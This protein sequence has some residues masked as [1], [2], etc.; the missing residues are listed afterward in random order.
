[1]GRYV[2][3]DNKGFAD[4]LRGEYVDKTGLV[5]L[6]D[7]TLETPRK[8]V[9]VSCPRRF[10]KSFAAQSIVAF[11][12]CGCDSRAFFEG[13]EVSRRDGWDEHLNQFNVLAL[14]MTAVMQSAKGTDT[15]R[16]ALDLILPELR[17]LLPEAGANAA[18]EG[19][20]LHSAL[21]D[22]VQATGRKF[23]FVIDEWDAPYRLMRENRAA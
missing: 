1:M 22:V 17:G 13:L 8:L 23:V 12:S 7:S 4:I 20:L 6:F 9:L 14:D 16:K 15:V 3:P 18:G 10:G 21:W 11:Y 5:S 19:D 2:N